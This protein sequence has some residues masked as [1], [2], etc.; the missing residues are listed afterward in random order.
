MLGTA[1]VLPN[2]AVICLL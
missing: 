2:V 1:S